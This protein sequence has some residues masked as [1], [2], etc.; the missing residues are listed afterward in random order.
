MTHEHHRKPYH[1]PRLEM[2][3]TFR[4]IT[5]AGWANVEDGSTILGARYRC[6]DYDAAGGFFVGGCPTS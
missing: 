5:H 6:T 1:T 3:G 2:L 4:D